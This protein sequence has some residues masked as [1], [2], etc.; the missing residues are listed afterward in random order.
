MRI[1]NIWMKHV[2]TSTPFTNCKDVHLGVWVCTDPL[3][4]MRENQWVQLIA[5][6]L[7]E[8]PGGWGTF[9]Q[10]GLHQCLSS[11]CVPPDEVHTS[12]ILGPGCTHWLPWSL[13]LSRS[14]LRDFR[15]LSAFPVSLWMM[16]LNHP[17][18]EPALSPCCKKTKP[19]A[20]VLA[21]ETC[22]QE[23]E[24]REPGGTNMRVRK[25]SWKW[26]LPHV[27]LED[28]EFQSSQ[29]MQLWTKKLLSQVTMF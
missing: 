17:S 19:C 11:L 7:S 13:E 2:P 25:P 29:T 16:A 9:L 4:T 21:D 24:A 20:V 14:D 27:V 5:L 18:W 10:D 28:S 3:V 15:S 12:S 23:T 6:V 1:K 22:C 26:V 8:W